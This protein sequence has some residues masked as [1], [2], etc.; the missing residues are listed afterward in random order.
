MSHSSF[1]SGT[2]KIPGKEWKGLREAV[3]DAFNAHQRYLLER[4]KRLRERLLEMKRESGRKVL[5][6][7]RQLVND[8]V[9]NELLD[10]CPECDRNDVWN[11]P[12]YYDEKGR[13][14]VQAPTKR[15]FADVSRSREMPPYRISRYGI[16]FDR[17]TKTVIWSV[18]EHGG[19]FEIARAHPV[20]IAFFTKLAQIRWVRGTG[21]ALV[22][23]KGE[24]CADNSVTQRFGPLGERFKLKR[25]RQHQLSPGRRQPAARL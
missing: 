11:A 22:G 10:G 19:G 17:S 2:I 9:L 25:G 7:E 20:A 6:D 13:L 16:E 1:E 12:L 21:G 5:D 8:G 3:A 4:A 23:S 14:Q 18:R 15:D 24:E